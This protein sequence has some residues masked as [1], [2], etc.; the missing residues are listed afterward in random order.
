MGKSKIEE[1]ADQERL[2]TLCEGLQALRGKRGLFF[3]LMISALQCPH[4]PLIRCIEN[5]LSDM[6]RRYVASGDTQ[7][8]AEFEALTNRFECIALSDQA[9]DLLFEER[10][11]RGKRLTG[12]AARD[13]IAGATSPEDLRQLID[14]HAISGDDERGA[15]AAR[16]MVLVANAQLHR[17]GGSRDDA[18][19]FL[20]EL[21][22][23]KADLDAAAAHLPPVIYITGGILLAAQEY[24]FETTVPCT[25]WPTPEE[26]ANV[27]SRKAEE[28]ISQAPDRVDRS[29]R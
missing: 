10:G 17:S 11:L 25:E 19:E 26:L 28:L 5:T 8:L 22:R 27:V 23:L 12:E 21:A 24:A 1:A 29:D 2:A 6:Q 14:G 16:A 13:A 18:L 4:E 15:A 3:G 7:K 20:D 9:A